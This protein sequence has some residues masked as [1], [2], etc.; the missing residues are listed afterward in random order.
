MPEDRVT[1]EARNARES[2]LRQPTTWVSVAPV[3]CA[4]H[5][6]ATPVLVLALPSFAVGTMA[7]QVLFTLSGLLALGFTAWAVASH[8]RMVAALPVLAGL[9]LWG[10]GL[11]GLIPGVAE[12]VTTVAGALI[13]AAG[14]VW[15]SWLRHLTVC[16]DCS[17]A[18]GKPH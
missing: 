1:T 2:V 14:L 9:A 12:E 3:L 11:F 5:C 18:S 15:S 16:P 7:E 4:A 17:C 6:V 8:G 10:G 13:L